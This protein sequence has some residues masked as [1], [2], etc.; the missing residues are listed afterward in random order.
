MATENPRTFEAFT[1]ESLKTET[2]SEIISLGDYKNFIAEKSAHLDSLFSS[3]NI[4][5]LLLARSELNDAIVI[6]ASEKFFS[7]KSGEINVIAVGGYGRQELHPYSD[8]DLLLLL[9]Q[10]SP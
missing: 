3:N 6:S 8:T 2:H 5:N 7:D 4:V 9:K 10:N 1:K